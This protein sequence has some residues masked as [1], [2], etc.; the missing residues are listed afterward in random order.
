MQKH[1]VRTIFLGCTQNPHFATG[2]FGTISSALV[3]TVMSRLYISFQDVRNLV[4]KEYL[5]SE[6]QDLFTH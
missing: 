2:L 5:R 4:A 6:K 3:V 1:F